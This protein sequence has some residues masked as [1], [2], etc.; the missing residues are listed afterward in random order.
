[1]ANIDWDPKKYVVGKS[2]LSASSG[3]SGA[4]F[5]EVSPNFMHEVEKSYISNI[6]R[7]GFCKEVFSAAEPYPGVCESGTI[8]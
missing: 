4:E 5:L 6:D 1:M 2:H 8:G 7:C 3:S